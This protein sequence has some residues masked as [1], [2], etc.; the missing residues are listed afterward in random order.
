MTPSTDAVFLNRVINDPS[1]KPWVSLGFKQQLDVTALLSNSKNI[2]LANEFGGFLLIHRAPG[3]YE[4][5]TQF[6]PEGRGSTALKAARDALEYLFV[7]TDCLAIMT[8]IQNDNRAA[9]RLARWVRFRPVEDAM[10]AG[11]EGKNYL[12]TIKQWVQE[13]RSC[14]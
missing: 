10:V 8:F 5:H 13:T 14:Q 9:A 7:K 6:L 2:F 4:L 12:L 1:V 3:M 11:F